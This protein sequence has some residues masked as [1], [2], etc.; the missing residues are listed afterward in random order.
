MPIAAPKRRPPIGTSSI[1]IATTINAALAG[2]THMAVLR[3]IL[4]HTAA[5]MVASSLVLPHSGQAE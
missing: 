3:K 2:M 4:F 5:L 1:G